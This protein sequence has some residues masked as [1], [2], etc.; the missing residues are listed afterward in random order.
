MKSAQLVPIQTL[1][2][3]RSRGGFDAIYSWPFEV[4]LIDAERLAR[5]ARAELV[6]PSITA[7]RLGRLERYC[8]AFFGS[9]FDPSPETRAEWIATVAESLLARGAKSAT[10]DR[11]YGD[12]ALIFEHDSE[13]LKGRAVLLG[14]DGKLHASPLDTD[15]LDQ[16]YVFFPPARE[17]TDED[18]EVEGDLDLKPP[19][20]LNKSLILMSEELTWNRQDGK[21]KRATPARR[22]LEDNRLVRRFKTVDLLEHVGR[23]LAKSRSKALRSDALRYAFNLYASARNIQQRQLRE[24][25]LRV[26]CVSG[27]LPA[28][29][30]L[31]S[32]GWRTGRARDLADLI[33]R[34]GPGSPEL[35]RLGSQLLAGPDEWPFKIA[36]RSRWVAFLQDIGVRDGL[37]PVQL[38]HSAENFAGQELVPSRLAARFGLSD[39]DGE[40]W[41]AAVVAAPRYAPDHPYTHYRARPAASAL[42]GQ[43]DYD[44]LDD[45]ARSLYATLVLEGL[46]SWAD[47]LDVVWER[48]S[49]HHRNARDPRTWPSPIRTFLSE[50]EWMP[51]SRPGERREEVFVRPS[52]AWYFSD[53]RGDGP[54]NF[55]PLVIHNVRRLLAA[56]EKALAAAKRLGLGDWRDARHAPRLLRHLAGLVETGGLPESGYLAFRNANEDAWLRATQWEPA[57]FAVAMADAAIVFARSGAFVAEP[58]STIED[59]Q[60]YVLNDRRSLA[61]RILESSGVAILTVD[62]AADTNSVK[63]LLT[64]LV[65]DRVTTLTSVDLEV[66]TPSGSFVPTADNPRLL[67][68]RLGWLTDLLHLILEAKRARRDTSGAARRAAVV[69]N[70]R[71]VRVCHLPSASISVGGVTVGLAGEVRRAVPVE[72]DDH[73]TLVWLEAEPPDLSDVAGVIALTPALCELLGVGDYQAEFALA[74]E[75]LKP[76]ANGAPTSE[77]YARI[78]D[79]D[80]RR[81]K[82]VLS[83]LGAPIDPIIRDLAPVL[84]FY[85]GVGSAHA[86]LALLG[87]ID[88][89]AA[90][91]EVIAELA[92]AADPS[93]LV[94]AARDAGSLPELRRQLGLDY[95]RFNA[96]LR[97]LGDPYSPIRNETG[98]THAVQHYVVANRE[99]I[100]H[101]LRARFLQTFRE[102]GPLANYVEVRDLIGISPDPRWL[103]EF[104]VPPDDLIAEYVRAWTTEHGTESVG[105]VVLDPLSELRRA[106]H[107]AIAAAVERALPLVEAWCRKHTV[108]V[109]E[110]WSEDSAI[111][112]LTEAAS[113]AGVLDFERLS[114]SDCLAWLAREGLWPVGMPASLDPATLELSDAE[115]ASARTAGAAAGQERARQRGIVSIDGQEFAADRDGYDA[116]IEHINDSLRPALLSVPLRA[117]PL[118]AMPNPSSSGG[119]P[120]GGKGRSIRPTRLSKEQAAAIGL[121]GETVAYAWLGSHYGD[122]FSPAGWK[123]SYRETIG[124]PP[125]DDTLGYD[126]EVVLKT[127]TVYFEVKA[128][129]GTDTAFELGESEVGAARDHAGSSRN[130]YWILFVVNALDADRRGLFVLPNPMDPA[131]QA[132]FRFPGSGLTCTFKLGG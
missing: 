91:T 7:E 17:R 121:I 25:N 84:A 43:A 31:F 99:A 22:F 34:G 108:P 38:P 5:D 55:S 126:F 87:Q 46:G 112:N 104:D 60:I 75:R 123:S 101:S 81:V 66:L 110:A 45:P 120:G 16:P 49:S 32:P 23:A 103:D 88:G 64:T 58:P 33:E 28:T 41:A 52:D 117:A 47:R 72:N 44:R 111:A 105:Q 59:A 76:M 14:D 119:G 116:I 40:R 80:T 20:S 36:D 92:P 86:L 95:A 100:L 124:E 21:V 4:S 83:H 77:E 13:A 78:L 30:A 127:R 130:A 2:G 102:G 11:F 79:L 74:L 57:E 3:G 69:E 71:R 98:H 65:G 26:P 39:S 62:E 42:P 67:E 35:A 132:F 10:W 97:E 24:L 128:T 113:A 61:A 89:E 51:T 63:E 107:G 18:D 114:E 115:L 12:L 6:A 1:P 118:A 9:G 85:A 93:I 109:P 15:D 129:A 48:F 27:W 29:R 19:A 54:P 50:T 131:N 68:G 94:A 8:R 90:L 56:D 96:V 70:L 82:E 106:N 53:V 122:Q 73:P 125:G 37:W